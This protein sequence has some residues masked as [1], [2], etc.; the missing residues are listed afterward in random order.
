MQHAPVPTEL[1]LVRAAAGAT[2]TGSRRRPL[3]TAGLSRGSFLWLLLRRIVFHRNRFRDFLLLWLGLRLFFLNFLRRRFDRRC[4][5]WRRF[6]QSQLL[7]RRFR[8]CF[9]FGSRRSCRG[10]GW[11]FFRFRFWRVNRRRGWFWFRRWQ[12]DFARR[13]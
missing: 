9:W 6:D 1:S 4:R 13:G 10:G 11:R 12:L 5:F 3:A 2:A 8:C 7:R